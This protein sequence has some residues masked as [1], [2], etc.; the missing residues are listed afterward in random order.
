MV[1][2]DETV[3]NER[4]RG[5]FHVL[6]IEQREVHSRVECGRGHDGGERHRFA[7]SGFAADEEIVLGQADVDRESVLTDAEEERI[8]ERQRG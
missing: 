3:R 1:R 7:G 8:P 6:T 2:S 5:Q 4:P